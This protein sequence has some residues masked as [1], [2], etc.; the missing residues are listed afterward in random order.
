MDRFL[1][2]YVAKNVAKLICLVAALALVACDRGDSSNSLEPVW[3]GSCSSAEIQAL[4]SDV[5]LSP[6]EIIVSSSSIEISSSSGWFK[7]GDFLNPDIEY[8][9]LVDS[10]DGK[11]YS[12]VVIGN[13]TW[14]A[15]NLN[16]ADSI[17]DP[18]LKGASRCIDERDEGCNVLGRLY[19]IKLV[20]KVDSSKL[21][22]KGL[23]YF[24]KDYQ[25]ICPDGWRIPSMF[26]WVSLLKSINHFRG[27]GV[28]DVIFSE[29][30]LDMLLSKKS[31]VD[32]LVEFSLN[33]D[34][35]IYVGTDLYG[36]SALPMYL[37]YWYSDMGDL[38]REYCCARGPILNFNYGYKFFR[39]HTGPY[40][41]DWGVIRCVKGGYN[42][43]EFSTHDD[44]LNPNVKYDTLVD[45]R[46]G[47]IYRTY[48]GVMAENL[49]YD[50]G[51]ALCYNNDE[52]LCA[53][54]GRLYDQESLDKDSLDGPCPDGWQVLW[55]L[56]KY[57]LDVDEKYVGWLLEDSKREQADDGYNTFP[58][59]YYE[60]GEF[61]GIGVVAA[62]WFKQVDEKSG[63]GRDEIASLAQVSYIGSYR[64]LD[65]FSPDVHASV[66][67]V[68][69]E[70]DDE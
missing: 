29:D 39:M 37:R 42:V 5:A 62:F 40:V 28:E 63:T 3:E 68:K 17:Q 14:M 36:F 53:L 65:V 20:S 1:K 21:L 27:A 6:G 61:Q 60:D 64:P 67:C 30:S 15:E 18:I 32:Q 52:R 57:G 47:Q 66:R 41:D 44:L 7:K 26:D 4:S 23:V 70:R 13:L 2:K 25:G 10:R 56:G 48:K 35:E 51:R 69:K 45:E 54:Y 11:T 50:D 46:D 55:N 24:D 58:S 19:D 16:Y 34:S 9:T 22:N 49:N 33:D 59:G 8:G 43:G 38:N 12:T 31:Y